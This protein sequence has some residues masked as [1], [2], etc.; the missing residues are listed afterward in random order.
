MNIIDRF[1]SRVEDY[2]MCKSYAVK[3]FNI[4]ERDAIRDAPDNSK[5]ECD[6]FN[7]P[8]PD[9]V[10]AVVIRNI[11]TQFVLLDL[12]LRLNLTFG[13]KS[14]NEFIEE[15][16]KRIMDY[17]SMNLVMLKN[18][19]VSKGF[20]DNLK[21]DEDMEVYYIGKYFERE[22]GLDEL[23]DIDSWKDFLRYMFPRECAYNSIANQFMTMHIIEI[24]IGLI[25]FGTALCGIG[26]LIR[27]YNLWR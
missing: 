18:N 12:A 9:R 8:L 16:A 6:V 22:Y 5:G 20:R 2:R 4:F 26:I 7:V 14:R 23:N 21:Y 19:L 11:M 10:N 15:H 24:I 27:L 25:K 17:Y 13:S 3:L 1:V